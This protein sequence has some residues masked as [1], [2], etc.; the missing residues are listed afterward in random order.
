MRE[1]VSKE[2]EFMLQQTKKK[3]RIRVRE[4]RATTIDKLVVNLVASQD[5]D[6]PLDGEDEEDVVGV[7]I[8]DPVK[9]L[10]QLSLME[11]KDLEKDI[12]SFVFLEKRASNRKYWTVC[13]S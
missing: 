1:W 9:L 12:A 13:T 10:E 2:D 8:V 6:T 5:A 3:A 4:G 11:V 7:N